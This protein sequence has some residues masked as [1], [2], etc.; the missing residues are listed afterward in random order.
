M[1]LFPRGFTSVKCL[2]AGTILIFISIKAFPAEPNLEYVFPIA[3]QQG[4]T[5]K[6]TL[7]GKLDPWPVKVWTDCAGLSFAA[8]TN[9]GKSSTNTGKVSVQIASDAP[10]GPHLLRVY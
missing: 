1:P 6:L 4:D 9:S 7:G 10:V 2:L 5:V 3:W 8:Q